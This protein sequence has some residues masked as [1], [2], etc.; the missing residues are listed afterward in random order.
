MADKFTRLGA[1][2][3]DTL[4]A[5]I[6]GGSPSLE[7]LEDNVDDKLLTQIYSDNTGSSVSG[8]L[9]E[10]TVVST[11]ITANT[12]RVGILVMAGVRYTNADTGASSA[13]TTL[14]LKI[15]GST[16]KT[17]QLSGQNG[18]TDVFGT[19]FFYYDSS[20]NWSGS[21]AVS[22]TAQNDDTQN[23]A[24]VDSLIILGI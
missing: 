19:A 5:T 2:E 14:R 12:V 9:T 22:I 11:T 23:T 8:T 16:V 13:G 18:S 3:G 21:I 1:G 15:G 6:A 24:Y 4:Y 7:K 17:I 20:Q 10:T